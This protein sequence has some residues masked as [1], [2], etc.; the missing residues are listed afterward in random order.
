MVVTLSYKELSMCVFMVGLV[1]SM[2]LLFM[3]Q[4]EKTCNHQHLGTRIHPRDIFILVIL[5]SFKISNI[6]SLLICIKQI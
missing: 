5:F 4:L 3:C 6:D 2:A 1:S